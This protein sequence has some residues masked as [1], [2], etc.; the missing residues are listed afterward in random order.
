MAPKQQLEKNAWEW[1][2]TTLPDSVSQQHIE[3]VYRIL[4]KPCEIAA[5]K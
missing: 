1:A 3:T 2:R 4:L 5:C